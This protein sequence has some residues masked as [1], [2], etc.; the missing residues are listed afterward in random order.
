M[1]YFMCVGTIS[2]GQ[3]N[4]LLKFPYTYKS[5]IGQKYTGAKSLI[6]VFDLPLI[7][8]HLEVILQL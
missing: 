8:L 7:C 2:L 6:Q 5:C 1:F 3:F 4:S